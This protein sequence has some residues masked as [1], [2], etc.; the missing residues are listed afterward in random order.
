[1]DTSFNSYFDKIFYI[2]LDRRWDRKKE[3]D[4]ELLKHD[5]VAERFTAHDG[6]RFK[7]RSLLKQ[8]EVACC[9]SHSD[10]LQMQIDN[11]WQRI[12]ILEDDVQFVDDV[13]EKFFEHLREIPSDWLMIY[14]GGNHEMKPTPL[15]GSERIK[16]IN[17][18]YTTSSYAITL[19][20][21]KKSLQRMREFV[22]QAD[23][24]YHLTCQKY[25]R[26]YV[27]Q[28]PLAWQRPSFSDIQ[29]CLKD[30]TKF[31]NPNQN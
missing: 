25:G 11:G 10:I 21:A 23:L 29:M 12:L 8:N 17:R 22:V 14:L 2:N 6:D 27:F 16:K 9:M 1:M 7:T 26:C 5:I 24:V 20:G 31:L 18:T 4:A 3:C 28:P 13:Q 19:E 15:E 30:Y